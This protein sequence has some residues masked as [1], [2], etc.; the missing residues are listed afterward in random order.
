MS[1]SVGS[2]CSSPESLLSM[3]RV[4]F[5]ISRAESSIPAIAGMFIERAN[6]A[7]CDVAPPPVVQKPITLSVSRFAV[8]E[9]VKSFAIMMQ[10]SGNSTEVSV[11]SRSRR[12]TRLPTSR[13]SVA[14]SANNALSRP[15][16]CLT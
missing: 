6:I 15:F 9:G 16:S 12:K 14:R 7:L 2:I 3:A 1:S 5:L 13:K 4:P 11:I 10:L 8:S